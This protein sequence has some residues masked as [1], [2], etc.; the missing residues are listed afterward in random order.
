MKKYLK[1][2]IIMQNHVNGIVPFAAAIAGLSAAQAFAVGAAAG[3][4][5][6]ASGGHDNITVHNPSLRLKPALD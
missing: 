1:P 6:T 4:A 5:L 2:T 3:L